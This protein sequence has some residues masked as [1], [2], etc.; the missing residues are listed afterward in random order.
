MYNVITRNLETELIVACRR[1]GL[2]V[3]V[4]NPIAGGLFSGKIKSKDMTPAEGRFSD[5]AA[6]GKMYRGR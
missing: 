4:Y 1:Y 3:V 2:D 5:T 6:S